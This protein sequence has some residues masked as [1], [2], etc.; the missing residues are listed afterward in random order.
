MSNPDMFNAPP[1]PVRKWGGVLI[2]D[3]GVWEGAVIGSGWPPGGFGMKTGP[4]GRPHLD[5][6]LLALVYTSKTAFLGYF[7][8]FS[9][10][11]G[12]QRQT[13]YTHPYR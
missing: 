6:S 3:F 4:G 10:H 9:V 8:L 5:P 2:F 7:T 12:S 11:T 13:H 1:F